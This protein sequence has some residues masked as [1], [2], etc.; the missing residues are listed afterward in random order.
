[1]TSVF[2]SFEPQNYAAYGIVFRSE[3]PLPEALRTDSKVLPDVHIRRGTVDVKSCDWID[4]GVLWKTTP[5]V[6]MIEI[7]DAGRYLVRDGA[8]IMVEPAEGAG[9]HEVATYLLGSVFGAL[10]HQRGLWPLHACAVQ[11]P[12]GAVLFAGRSGMGKSTLAWALHQRGYTILADDISALSIHEDGSAT[13]LPSI[14]QVKLSPDVASHLGVDSTGLRRDHVK[15]KFITPVERFS[16]G[17]TSVRRV[18]FLDLSDDEDV[19][20]EDISGTEAVR[21]LTQATF[22]KKFMKGLGR[23]PMH[24][25][26][27]N[28]LVGSVP[29]TK[30]FRPIELSGLQKLLEKVE[31]LLR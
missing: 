18:V 28:A 1:M 16:S 26:R 21:H 4:E 6:F 15:G 23:H 25:Q 31:P 30:V 10:L 5:G 27:V 8:E 29:L 22:R 12:E 3:I 19:S 9:E 2:Q 11:T 24:F 17:P 14:P 20:M 7:D 13:V